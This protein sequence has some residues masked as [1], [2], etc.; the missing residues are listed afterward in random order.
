MK[1]RRLITSGIALLLLLAVFVIDLIRKNVELEV[2]G[3]SIARDLM[4]LAAVV[5]IAL[6]LRSILARRAPNPIRKLGFALIATVALVLISGL[7]RMAPG[8][9]FDAKNY[10]LIPLDYATQ[11]TASLLGFVFSVF[12]VVVVLLLTDLVLFKRRRSTIRNYR[13]FLVLLVLTALS[14][15][16]LKPLESGVVTGILFGLTVAFAIINSFRLSWIVYLTKR[17]KLFSLLYGFFLFAGLT[18]INIMIGQSGPTQEAL[19]YY[20][21][22]L[23]QFVMLSCIFANVYFGMT[24]VST[25]FHLPTAEAFERKTTEISSLHNLSRLVNQVFDFQ[26]LVETVTSMTLQVCEARSCWLELIHPSSA[27]APEGASVQ[28]T[29]SGYH[30]EVVGMKNIAAGEIEDLLSVHRHTLRDE[31]LAD[32]RA[33]VVD[34]VR[35]DPRF[36]HL[37]RGTTSVGSMIVVPLV[38]H[39]GPVGI[40]YVTKENEFGFFKDDVD[41]VSAFADQATVAIENSRLIKKSIERERLLREMMLAQEMQRKLLPQALPRLAMLDIAALSTPAFEVGGD[42]YD[43]LRIDDHRLGI[44]VGDV[45][46][47]GVSAAFYMSEVKGIFQALGKLYPSPREFMIRANEALAGSIDK[48]SFIS[49]IYVVVD[50]TSGTLTLSRAGHC[51]LLVVSGGSGTYI[52]PPGMGLG[53]SKGLMFS[54]SIEEQTI[55]LDE[56]DLCIMYTDGVTE[57]RR[58]DDEFGYDRLLEVAVRAHAQPAAAVKDEIL[59]SVKRHAAHETNDDDLTIVVLKWRGN[60]ARHNVL[61]Q[62][63]TA[64]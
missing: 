27:P 39:A 42:Y 22:P 49:L 14:T 16:T 3:L 30:V 53:L 35:R 18:A 38:S 13:I 57:A 34:D 10:A 55:V 29:A 44:V 33:L 6:V 9:G 32:R 1:F 64:R 23:K 12:G 24:F 7:L 4:L 26:E 8:G 50:L 21:L 48:H 41:V 19:L 2:G 36:V 11:F 40:L 59:E 63:E 28:L 56:D 60:G 17:E 15:L 20:S 45:S 46:G 62:A 58:G 52:R 61:S 47:K 54:G 51:P 43:V 31:V 37:R 25:L 5:Q